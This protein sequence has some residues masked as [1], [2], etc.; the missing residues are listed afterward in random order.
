MIKLAWR[1]LAADRLRLAISAGGVALALVLILVMKGVFAGSE[2]HAVAYMRNQPAELWVMQEGVENLHMATSMLA[3]AVLEQVNAEPGVRRAVGVLYA[4]VGVQMEDE[5]VF[6]YVFGVEPEAP[7]GG[8][9]SL[10]RGR[11]AVNS[12]EIVLDQVLAARHGLGLGDQV[13]I[14]DDS[15]TIV[16]LTEDNF[17]IATSLVFVSKQSLADMLGIPAD[18]NSYILV[19]LAP[20]TETSELLSR[21]EAL[22]DLNVLDR[23]AFIASDQQLIR[24]MGVDVLKAMNTV[25]YVVGMLVIG[26]SVYTAAVERSREY[27]ILLAIGSSRRQLRSV[28]LIQAG[29]SALLGIAAG[30]LAAFAAAWLISTLLPEMLVRVRLTD[31]LPV[32]VSLGGVTIVAALIPAAQ[33]GRVDPM[34]AFGA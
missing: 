23:E 3:P 6:S 22:K 16:G 13:S 12:D 27:G 7:F 15:L 8:P 21:L 11:H 14:L 33:V 25:A 19:E 1:N 34:V 20:D 32:L 31:V 2:E 29:L 5:L 26:F 28:V 17:G 18:W 30:V 24:Q 4:N 9:W 10:A